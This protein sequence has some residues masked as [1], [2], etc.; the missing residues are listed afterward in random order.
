MWNKH[1]L[2]RYFMAERCASS[3]DFPDQMVRYVYYQYMSMYIIF[4]LIDKNTSFTER[5]RER[6]RERDRAAPPRLL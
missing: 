5:E 6:E 4:F 1:A 3:F 2:C